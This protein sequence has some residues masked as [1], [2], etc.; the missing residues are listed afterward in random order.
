LSTGF[1]LDGIGPCRTFPSLL[2]V[3]HFYQVKVLKAVRTSRA[4]DDH[5][6]ISGGDRAEKRLLS[7]PVIQ[8]ETLLRDADKILSF[9]TGFLEK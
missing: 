9:P 3:C 8:R 7:K 6:R 2:C 4:D 5:P 1:I